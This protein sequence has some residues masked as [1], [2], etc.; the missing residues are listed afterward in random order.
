MLAELAS[1]DLVYAV[2]CLAALALTLAPAFH[3]GTLD[4]GIPLALEVGVLWIMI[5]DITLGNSLGLYR[6]PWFDKLL[7]VSSSTLV[8]G[9]GFLAI[10]ALHETHGARCHPWLDGAA[11]LL[12]TLGVGALW[13]I[14]EYAADALFARRTQGSPNMSALDDTM[15]D[16][17][18]DGIGG[19]VGALLG[20][21]YLRRAAPIA[22]RL[23]AFAAAGAVNGRGGAA[24]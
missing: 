5:A 16:L 6:L 9:I 3:A 18:L 8:G 7:H 19:A 15:L 10:Y 2:F 12:I 23:A 11:I 21:R 14:A 20:P 4:A 13:E 1:G 24:A 22:K 17:A